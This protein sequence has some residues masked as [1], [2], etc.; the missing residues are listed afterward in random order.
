MTSALSCAAREAESLT[1]QVLE[2]HSQ[3]SPKDLDL[4]PSEVVNGLFGRLVGL[5]IKTISEAVTTT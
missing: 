2:I 3:L 4:R 1:L 5:S